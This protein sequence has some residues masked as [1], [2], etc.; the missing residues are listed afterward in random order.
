M[1][2]TAVQHLRDLP[3]GDAGIMDTL[4]AMRALVDDALDASRVV[5]G[6]AEAILGNAPTR[7]DQL[8]AVFS[9]LTKTVRFAADPAGV[10]H[11]R[12]PFVMLIEIHRTGTTS[13]DCDDMATLGAALLKSVGFPTAF[14][15]ASNRPTGDFNHVLFGAYINGILITLDPQQKMF[16]RLPDTLTRKYVFDL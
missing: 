3:D 4:W 9:W 13:G 10:E 1:L 12:H 15:V 16:D 8:L 2:N 6:I 7:R 14:I 11:V 5:R